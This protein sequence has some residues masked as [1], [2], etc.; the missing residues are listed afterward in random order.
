MKHT[1][2]EMEQL[3][4][5]ELKKGAAEES[6]APAI[7]TKAPETVVEDEPETFIARRELDLGE[8][9]GAEIFEAEGA[10]KEEALE[11]LAD[12]IADAKLN[13]TKKI[14]QQEAELKDFRARS[15]EPP[16]PKE[17]SAD[18]EY[19]IAQELQKNPSKA[20]RRV[21]K[22]LTGYEIEEFATAKQA[23]DAVI[24]SQRQNEAVSRFVATHDDY[25]DKGDGGDRNG[26][27]MRM[28][29]AELKLPVTSENLS[30]AYNALKQS[31]LLTLKN[32]EEAHADTTEKTEGSGRIVQ[33]RVEAAQTRTRKTSTIGTHNRTT[34]T[35]VNTEPSEDEAYRMPMEKLRELANKQLA[36][37]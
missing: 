26:Q 33:P 6:A 14:R 36:A 23:A 19:V 15:A 20:I 1:E 21:F 31:G 18:D 27:L 2:A 22:E 16:K 24:S 5:D 17:L 11:A 10:T 30:K 34:A 32:A 8:G 3:S 12:K 29:L 28:K 7:E 25:E 4:L 13:A 37:R 9:A 35:P